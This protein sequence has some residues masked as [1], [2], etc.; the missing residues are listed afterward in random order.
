MV[1]IIA[2]IL[3]D[4]SV[5]IRGLNRE[6]PAA[7]LLRR[8]VAEKRLVFSPIV[9]AEFLVKAEPR[10]KEALLALAKVCPLL[11]VNLKT[12]LLVGEYRR[13]YLSKRIKVPMYDCL[14][15]AQCNLAHAELATCNVQDIPKGMVQLHEF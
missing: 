13:R 12:A 7:G 14:I 1:T 10:D 15:A 5:L 2:P 3:P 8:A 11:P 9:L 6:E 4:T